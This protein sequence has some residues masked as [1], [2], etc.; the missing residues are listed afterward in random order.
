MDEDELSEVLSQLDGDKMQA[1][2]DA[3]NEAADD[4]NENHG[5][6]ENDQPSA[7]N[8]LAMAA[9]N[10]GA[11]VFCKEVLNILNTREPHAATTQEAQH[12]HPDAGEMLMHASRLCTHVSE[13]SSQT[14]EAPE[15]PTK[16]P[17][18]RF[19]DCAASFC[20]LVHQAQE[21]GGKPSSDE[22]LTLQ[23]AGNVCK[24]IAQSVEGKTQKKKEADAV[25][26]IL[27][28][29]HKYCMYVITELSSRVKRSVH[30][31]LGGNFLMNAA[32]L[33][34]YLPNMAIDPSAEPTSRLAQPGVGLPEA[35]EAFCSLLS[36]Q[37][38][39]PA[40]KHEHHADL[41]PFILKASEVCSELP[42]H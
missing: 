16:G 23:Y 34:H 12:H 18:G 33:C 28:G 38:G 3:A 22:Q 32:T 13:T 14:R 39:N 17:F 41:L 29:G 42:G 20:S 25:K 36:R 15:P 27:A 11:G 6:G 5:G 21:H 40:T 10:K 24:H 31:E 26:L 4:T 9:M 7:T 2:V 19:M 1:A 35:T 37:L 30:R 8:P